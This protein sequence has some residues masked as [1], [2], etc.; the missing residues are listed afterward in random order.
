MDFI[1][2]K[3]LRVPVRIGIYE[4]EQHLPQIVTLDLEIGLPG[5]SMFHTDMIEDTIDY[6]QVVNK[7]RVLGTSR[8]FGLVEYFADRVAGILI[9]EFRAPWAKVRVAKLGVIPEAGF[10]GVSIER[11]RASPRFIELAA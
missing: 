11:P 10:V 7:I 3:D 9:D 4:H 2:I 6:G 1:L 8:H 5:K